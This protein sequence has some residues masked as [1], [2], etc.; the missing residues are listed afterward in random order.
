MVTIGLLEDEIDLRGEIAEFL[1]T[2]GY[3]VLE[4]GTIHEFQ[5]LIP[6]IQLA[7]VDIG[8]PDG[9]G[10]QVA[11]YLNHHAPQTGVI[12][13]TARGEATDKIN[14][15]KYGADK[16]LTKPIKFNELLAH[17]IALSRR[18]PMNQS[19]TLNR[20][21]HQLTSPQN[22]TEELTSYEFVFL[23]LLV[24]NPGEI[25]SRTNIAKAFGVDWLDYDE[26]HLD[27]L[28]SRF[29]KR[30]KTNTDTTLPIKTAHGQGYLFS[31]QIIV[32]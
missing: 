31:E 14:G 22:I 3:R 23:E 32:I 10:F 30:W 15:L 26:R 24:K 2:Q 28:V 8:L 21:Q 5:S 20:I 7:I 4:A 25:V 11:D 9:D 13:L 6:Q 29:R 27:Q 12:I 17:I 16:Y 19:W 1:Q 18:I